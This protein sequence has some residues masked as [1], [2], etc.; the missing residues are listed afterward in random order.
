M[1]EMSEDEKNSALICL[2]RLL[3]LPCVSSSLHTSLLCLGSVCC[4]H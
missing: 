4:V 3:S 1:N 2:S